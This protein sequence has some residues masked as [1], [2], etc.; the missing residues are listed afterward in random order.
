MDSVNTAICL[1]HV[2]FE[3]PGIFQACLN[4][5]GYLVQ[6]RLVPT[7]GLPKESGDLLLI[8]GGPMSVNDSTNWIV[9]EI[10]FIKTSMT[11]NIPIVGVCLGAQLLARA[12]GVPVIRG[13]SLRLG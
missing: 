5:R 6:T 1:Q 11:K 8:M 7:Q 4:Q 13:P 9:E 2:P 3:G 10:D 12:L